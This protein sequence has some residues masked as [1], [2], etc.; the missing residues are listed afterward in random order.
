MA[1]FRASR[2]WKYYLQ[3]ILAAFGAGLSLYLLVQHTRLKTGIQGGS[4]LC[5]LGKYADCNVVNA[6]PHSEIA[7]IPLAALGTL[8]F[9]A[10]F[11]FSLIQPPGSRGFA[12]S[13]V[14]M[15][16]A[17]GLALLVDLYLLAIQAFALKTFCLFC[18][19]TYVCTVGHLTLNWLQRAVGNRD[20]E[21]FFK[22][23]KRV[24]IASF[25]WAVS[26]VAVLVG[27]VGLFQ[28]HTA[29]VGASRSASLEQ[30]KKAFLETWSN[31]PSNPISLKSADPIWGNPNAKVQV[32]VF[33]DFECPHCQRA[34]FALHTA[35]AVNEKKVQMIFKQFPLDSSCN[36]LLQAPM[37][38]NACALSYLGYCANQKNRFWDFHDRVFFKL[39]ARELSS[40][41]D[42]LYDGVKTLFTRKEFDECL[43]NPSAQ[44][45]TRADI[46]LGKRVGVDSTPSVFINGKRVT[47]AP[48]VDLIQ[49]LVQKELD[50]P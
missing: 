37:H 28:Y 35:L 10:L 43:A 32:V 19:L 42:H 17:A 36:P 21:S 48:T 12:R 22:G 29:T 40:S 24:R 44:A 3:L 31:R 30:S 47:F 18:C 45:N 2:R 11:V 5:S 23:E 16:R 7:G 50:R 6:S 14:W 33:S 13:Q 8:F 9:L 1:D 39:S 49:E 27:A 26:F 46:E 20:W 38:A 25:A 4:S 15:A 41:H 34:A